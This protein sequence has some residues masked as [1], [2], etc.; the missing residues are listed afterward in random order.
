MKPATFKALVLLLWAFFEPVAATR[1]SNAVARA[2]LRDHQDP[3]HSG[4]DLAELQRANPDAYA[5][6]KS[7]LMKRQL[8]L[9]DPKHPSHSFSRPADEDTAAASAP[10]DG[11]GVFQSLSSPTDSGT[12]PHR[13]WLNWKPQDS[14]ANDDAMVNSVLGAVAQLKGTKPAET[15]P[16]T[17]TAA[18]SERVLSQ[19]EAETRPDVPQQQNTYLKALE[20]PPKK[21][22]VH[23]AMAD[24]ETVAVQPAPAIVQHPKPKHEN[25]YLKVIGVVPDSE[26]GPRDYLA[27]FSWGDE[28]Q[29]P[30]KAVAARRQ[31]LRADV[32]SVP[33]MPSATAQAPHDG[34]LL[35]WLGGSKVTKAPV[36][37]LQKKPTPKSQPEN[38]YLADLQ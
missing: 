9:L 36:K 21:H 3:A 14:A 30:K 17:H 2:W 5:I 23:S 37:R 12:M 32:A 15:I 22:K 11:P 25:S 18:S 29:K 19:S 26:K 31:A 8:G 28:D 35:T 27:S 10:V 16:A 6:V 20:G 4:D 7:L 24:S 1:S 13:N 33:T 38:K 34:S